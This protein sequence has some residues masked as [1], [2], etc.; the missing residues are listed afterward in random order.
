M[1]CR[2]VAIAL[3][4]AL[5]PVRVLAGDTPTYPAIDVTTYPAVEPARV[6]AAGGAEQWGAARVGIPQAWAQSEGA[7]V[8]AA[9][10]DSGVD[11]AHPDLAGRVLP[12]RNVWDGGDTGDVCG[13]GTHLA[14]IVAAV[15]PGAMLLPVK[16]MADECYGTYSA[17][18]D[19]IVYAADAG[20]QVIL[21]ASGAYFAGGAL[22]EAVVY[23]QERGALVVAAAGNGG[24]SA[25]FYPAA[26]AYAVAGTDYVAGVYWR[27]DYGP[28]IAV[29]APAVEIWSAAPGGLYAIRSGTSMAAAHA[30]G[31]AALV[32]GARPELTAEGV[33]ALLRATADDCGEPGRDDRCGDGRVNAWRATAPVQAWLPW[34][35]VE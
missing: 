25:P 34:V 1:R 6:Y 13:H 5:L 17:L 11:A 23:A 7:G 15:A 31:A 27:S 35:R 30:A 20:A 28:H 33:A 10:V 29:A 2:A 14:G 4:L 21:I 16:A 3:L 9:I 12:G 24:C 22:R 18:I 32:W 19:G 26:Y 8:V